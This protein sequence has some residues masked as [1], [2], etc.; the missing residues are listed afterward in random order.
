M[1]PDIIELKTEDEVMQLPLMRDGG[2]C[3][4]ALNLMGKG[5]LN[6]SFGRALAQKLKAYA[7]RFDVIVAV[8]AKSLALVQE[9]AQFLG[10]DEYVVLRKSH[11]L[12]MGKNALKVDSGS[13]TTPGQQALWLDEYDIP[14]LKGKRILFVDDVISTGK[15]KTAADELFTMV[16]AAVTVVA[17]V[18]T[19]GK[20]MEAAPENWVRLGHIP[21]YDGN[22]NPL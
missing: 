22:E 1:I 3:L 7:G 18:A 13:V 14:L 21:L 11:K 16:Q 2:L 5:R 6:R 12:Y 15:T 4:Y 9:L 19:E 17:C 8:E 20:A 10:A